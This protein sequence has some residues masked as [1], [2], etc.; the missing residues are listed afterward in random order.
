MTRATEFRCWRCGT[1]L[2]EDLLPVRR[3]E[4]CMV[5]NADLHVCKMCGFFN[6]SL[7]DACAETIATAVSN[8]ERSNYCEYFKP[9]LHA[10]KGGADSAAARARNE[11]EELFGEQAGDA[12]RSDGGENQSELERLFGI[13]KD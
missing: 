6:P 2:T 10:Y 4:V 3:A 9:S 12:A 5:C 8:K 7:A 13:K 1:Q 11:L